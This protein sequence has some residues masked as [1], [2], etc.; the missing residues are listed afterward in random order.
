MG[1]QL[2]IINPDKCTGCGTCIVICPDRIL[3][4]DDSGRPTLI[5]DHCMQCGHCYA[6]CPTEAIAVPFLEDPVT[7]ASI[8]EN[9]ATVPSGS[10]DPFILLNLMKQRRSCRLYS[11]KPVAGLLLED[12]VKAGITAPSGT[13]SQGWKFLLLP[14]REDVVKLGEATADFYRRLNQK[15]A[16]P[17]L[18]FIVRLFGNRS[19]D[20][21]FGKYYD[22]VEIALEGWDQHKEDRLFHGAPAAIVVAADKSSSWP[23]EDALLASQNILLMAQTLGL[24]SCLIGFVVEAARR[25]AAINRLLGLDKG[26]RIYSV[27]ALG[28]PAVEFFRPVGRKGGQPHII[29]FSE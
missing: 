11:H 8:S 27:I 22:T 2:P 15:A 12:L 13:N 28:Y 16:N 14:E 5:G 29:K 10:A 20:G 1:Q 18:R 7:F 19:L 3:Q 24:G 25:E 21:Y 6:V 9:D 23:G 26:H 4:G 17:L